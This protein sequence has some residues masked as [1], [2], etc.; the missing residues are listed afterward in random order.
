M[1]IKSAKALNYADTFIAQ[2]P[3]LDNIIEIDVVVEI[4]IFYASRRP[5]LDASL[6]L[7]LMQGRIYKNDRLVKQQHL[8]WNLD[9]K[10]PRCIIRVSPMAACNPK[11]SDG[12]T[13]TKTQDRRG[14]VATD[15]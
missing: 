1:F 8:Y 11:G 7:D 5:D 14:K 4:E 2:C 10:E 6:I 15:G 13:N 3:V 9:I 12:L